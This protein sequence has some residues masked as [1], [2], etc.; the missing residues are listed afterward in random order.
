MKRIITRLTVLIMTFAWLTGAFAYSTDPVFYGLKWGTSSDLIQL[1]L[2]EGITMGNKFK[3]VMRYDDIEYLDR[4]GT[5]LLYLDG[6]KLNAVQVLVIEDGTEG[7][8][9]A[10][11]NYLSMF[12]L[13]YGQPVR[14]DIEDAREGI[15]A[16]TEEGGCLLWKTGDTA[17]WLSD[18]GPGMTEI[19]FRQ[20]K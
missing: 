16:E 4:K 18:G 2:G 6:D 12:R 13:Q 10:A 8:E 5:A 15:V 9:P 14:A 7:T 3:M 19:W 20:L 11:L 17:I 1:V